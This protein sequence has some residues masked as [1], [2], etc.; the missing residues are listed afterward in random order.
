M[1]H[2]YAVV[3]VDHQTAT[4]LSFDAETAQTQH[5]RAHQHPTAQHASGV[6]AEHEFFAAVC[7]A[8]AGDGQILVAAGHVASADFHHYVDKHQ[9]QT[10][11]RIAG[12]E[13]VDH[14]SE[15]Q[16]LAQARSFFDRREHLAAPALHQSR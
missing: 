3:W 10:A 14:P 16:L 9:P 2:P 13:I 11:K 4:I 8:L 15:K 5:V 7:A 1:G 12:Y 6:R